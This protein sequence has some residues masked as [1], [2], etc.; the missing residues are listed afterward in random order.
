MRV[1]ILM[2]LIMLAF[3]SSAAEIESLEQ[4]WLSI[5]E[6]EL[7]AGCIQGVPTVENTL[8]GN[9]GL[10]VEEWL[11]STCKGMKRYSVAYYPSAHFPD[12]KSEFE[13]TEKN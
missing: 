7:G 4:R 2:T 3:N 6:K 12:K 11:I 10:R 5:I 8:S 1:F 9:N 13:V